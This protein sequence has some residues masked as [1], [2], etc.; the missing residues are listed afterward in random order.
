MEALRNDW[1]ALQKCQGQKH[2][3]ILKNCS[4]LKDYGDEQLNTMCHLIFDPGFGITYL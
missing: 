1:P 3:E 4:R 2:T